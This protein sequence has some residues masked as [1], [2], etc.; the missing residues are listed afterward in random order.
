ME[1]V[2][3]LTYELGLHLAVYT[4]IN[5]LY[6]CLL[7]RN[8]E[9]K[10]RKNKDKKVRKSIKLW[11]KRQLLRLRSDKFWR[12]LPGLTIAHAEKLLFLCFPLTNARIGCDSARKKRPTN[13][14]N[15]TRA[16]SSITT[17]SDNSDTLGGKRV[18]CVIVQAYKPVVWGKFSQIPHPVCSCVL[19]HFGVVEG[20]G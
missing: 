8:K 16:I 12:C 3:F 13:M 20:K 5:T 15:F 11:W 10:V 19:L 2:S 9:R 6:Q 14:S 4:Y 1:R 17:L 18:L 7:I